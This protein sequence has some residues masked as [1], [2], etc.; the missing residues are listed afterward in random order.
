MPINMSKLTV[1]CVLATVITLELLC[2]STSARVDGTLDAT[3]N[4]SS[5]V[6]AVIAKIEASHIFSSSGWWLNHNDRNLI[7]IFLR[8]MAY[9]ETDDGLKS[10]SAGLGIW[11]VNNNTFNM[12]RR[13]LQCDSAAENQIRQNM[14]NSPILNIDW[15]NN[16]T[17]AN[18]S[19][20]MYSGL[21]TVLYVDYLIAADRG[22]L[23]TSTSPQILGNLWQ[24]FNFHGTSEELTSTWAAKVGELSR[25]ES[26]MIN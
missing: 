3:R 23:P 17:H 8:Q 25:N 9:V 1:L 6:R 21:A 11:N 12:T 18:L 22:N 15:C 7:L 13:H 2:G 16:I 26:K 5:V 4:G 14:L 19:V 24:H 20:P 10:P